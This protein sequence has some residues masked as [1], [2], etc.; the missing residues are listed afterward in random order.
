VGGCYDFETGVL[1]LACVQAKMPGIQANLAYILETLQSVAPG[2]QIP[3]MSYWD[4]FL[5]T[6]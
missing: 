4:L 5:G 2:V 3:G 1:D 6:G